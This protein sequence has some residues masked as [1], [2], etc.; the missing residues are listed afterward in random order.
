MRALPVSG[1]VLA[2]IHLGGDA[3][4]LDQGGFPA[5][6]RGQS[7]PESSQRFVVPAEACKA[8][9]P[10]TPRRSRHPPRRQRRLEQREGDPR[11]RRSVAADRHSTVSLD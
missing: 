11:T 4:R 1:R 8:R 2:S 3:S 5:R 6:L 7:L 10:C 9:G